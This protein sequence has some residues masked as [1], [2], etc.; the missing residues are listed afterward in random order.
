VGFP[1]Y[2][3]QV[4]QQ[5]RAVLDV[6]L[7]DTN[8]ARIINKSQRNKYRQQRDGAAVR[9]QYVIYDLVKQWGD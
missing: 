4:R 8:K 9:S 7:R 6:Q 3:E 1:I 2:D 5:L